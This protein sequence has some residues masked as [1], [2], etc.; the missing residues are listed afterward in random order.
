MDKKNKNKKA[1]KMTSELNIF[2]AF[3]SFYFNISSKNSKTSKVNQQTVLN[4]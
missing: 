4:L 3:I 2:R 1:L